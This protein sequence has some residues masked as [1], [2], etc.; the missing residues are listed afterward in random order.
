LSGDYG[1]ARCGFCGGTNFT[2]CAK[3]NN[4]W[5]HAIDIAAN[6]SNKFSDVA[7]Q[8]YGAYMTAGFDRA[9]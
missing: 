9:R 7:V 2:N 4:S 3:N 1:T 6:Y 8:L 5:K